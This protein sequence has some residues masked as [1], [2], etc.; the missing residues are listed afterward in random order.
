LRPCDNNS[1]VDVFLTRRVSRPYRWQRT[2]GC[3]GGVTSVSLPEELAPVPVTFQ[4]F[5]SDVTHG[6]EQLFHVE[7]LYQEYRGLHCSGLSDG[8]ELY[9][10][11]ADIGRH[12]TIDKLAGMALLEPAELP[13][14]MIFTTGRISSEML[15]KSARMRAEVVISR[16]SPTTMSVILAEKLGITLIG[17][18]RKESFI[19]YAHPVRLAK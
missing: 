19:V 18:A 3:T 4:V 8:K 2:S 6:M 10:H 7:G 13:H 15:Q 1:N 16:T 11:A 12:N 14:R 5:P 9:Y 17:Y